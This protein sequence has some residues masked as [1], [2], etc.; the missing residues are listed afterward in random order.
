MVRSS[1]TTFPAS[2]KTRA[3]GRS[4]RRAVALLRRRG[5]TPSGRPVLNL[6]LALNY[7]LGGFDVAGY[8]VLNL[9]IHLAAGLALFGV[10]RRTLTSRSPARAVRR[11]R[12]AARLRRRADLDRAPAEHR[13]R[14]LRRP[15]RR[16][17]R[18][19]FLLLTLYCAIRGWTWARR[20][21][22]CALGMG[23]KETM[24]VAPALV[25]LWDR[26][27]REDGARR[28]RM[29]GAL[30]ATLIVVV[31][32]MLSETQG[33]TAVLRL[34]GYVGKVP[35]DA[36]TP[37]SYLWTQAASSPTTSR[38]CSGRGRSCSTTTTGRRRTRR[39]TCCRRRC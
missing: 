17:P 28:W 39:S 5:S 25:V 35:G 19:L 9:A 8:H 31:L 30:A 37:W 13:G 15:A 23:S 6:T 11:R 32:P 14:H 1:S 21:I 12:D 20:A 18:G 38:W 34:L 33:R 36:W 10:V 4:G 27:F 3:S 26:L 29:Y 16:E 7:A 2:S 24:I 22:A